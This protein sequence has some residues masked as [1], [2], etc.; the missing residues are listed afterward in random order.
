MVCDK[1][2]LLG[3]SAP[4]DSYLK[5]DAIIAIAL[6]IGARAIHPGYG[7]LSEMLALRKLGVDWYLSVHRLMLCAMGGKMR[8]QAVDGDSRRTTDTGLSW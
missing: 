1:A 8:I 7:F 3:G 2:H 6:E 5:G 4:K